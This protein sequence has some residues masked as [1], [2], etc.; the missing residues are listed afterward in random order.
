MNNLFVLRGKMQEI[1]A[2]YSEIVDKGIQFVLAL[3]TFFLINNNIGFM[4]VLGQPVVTLALAVVCTALPVIVTVFAAAALVLCHLYAA[5]L[6]V[7]LVTAVIFL[8]MFAFYLRLIPEKAVI[9][10]LTPIAFMLKMPYVIPI[11][12]ALV[13]GPSTVLAIVLGVIIFYILRYIKLAVPAFQGEETAGMLTQISAYVKQIF[14]DKQMWVMIIAFAICF[15]LVYIIRRHAMDYAWKVA[16]AVG[17]VMNII[18]ITAGNIVLGEHTA[19]GSLIGGSIIAIVLGLILEFFVF[20]VDY[21]KSENLQ[22]EDDEYYYYVKAVPKLTVSTQEKTIKRI[23]ERYEVEKEEP[24]LE[25]EVDE[26]LLAQSL[27]KELQ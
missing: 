19:Y 1:Y 5:S 4:K 7:M 2:K 23:N 21:A 15:M 20:S 18:I 11:A 14:Q 24:S 13:A 12:C 27:E 17:A 10:L 16:I 25:S 3:T 8:I 9:I 26:V 22:F 6:G